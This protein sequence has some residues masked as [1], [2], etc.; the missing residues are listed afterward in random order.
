MDKAP[1]RDL[2][3]AHAISFVISCLSVSRQHTEQFCPHTGKSCWKWARFWWGF[4]VTSSG[5]SLKATTCPTRDERDLL[6][7][8]LGH[9]MN[10]SFDNLLVAY[11]KETFVPLVFCCFLPTSASYIWVQNF[12][13]KLPWFTWLWTLS[14]CRK[15]LLGAPRC[16][17]SMVPGG[18]GG[19]LVSLSN[20]PQGRSAWSWAEILSRW[21]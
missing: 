13:L 21:V 1:T 11:Q 7:Q 15:A 12:S 6:Q 5:D 4:G 3:G 17:W 16:P 20:V 10:P 9:S 14:S 8:W 19:E 18:A 2:E